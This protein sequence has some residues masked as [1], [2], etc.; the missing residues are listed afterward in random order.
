MKIVNVLCLVGYGSLLLVTGCIGET[1]NRHATPEYGR[2]RALE[3]CHPYSDCS[4][5]VWVANSKTP[6]EAE[7]VY[8][9]CSQELVQGENGW[10]E[11]TVALG[12][13][14]NRCMESKGYR[15]VKN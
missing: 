9:I 11:D 15:L 13:E 4:R 1:W 6:E 7:Q 14:I 8:E 10:L 12:L 3:V 2:G 5:G